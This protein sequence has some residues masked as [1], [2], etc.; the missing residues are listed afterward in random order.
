MVGDGRAPRP[1]SHAPSS[2]PQSFQAFLTAFTDTVHARGLAAVAPPPG[3]P[4]PRPAPPVL[5]PAA[6]LVAVGDLHG[7]LPKT[8]R[9]LKLAGVLG[10]DGRWCGGKAT[11][12][13]VGDI[14]D[15][16]GD[17]VAI[18]YLL[19]RLSKE[20]AAA[21]GAVHVLLGNH[22][23]LNVAG[24]YRYASPSG[25]DECD[26]VAAVDAIAAAFAAK[27]GCREPPA[28]PAVAAAVAA[29]PPAD[30]ARAALLAPGAPLT[31]RFLAPN[32][33]ALQVGSTVFVHGGLLP[34]HA[35]RGAPSLARINADTAAWMR[36]EAPAMPDILKGRDAVVWARDY[37]HE[38]AAACDCDAL[39][40]ALR[41]LPGAARMVVGHTIQEG[42]INAACGGAVLRV[43]VGLSAGCGDGGVQVLVVDRDCAVTRLVEGGAS[44]VRVPGDTASAK[45]GWWGAGGA[46]AAGGGGHPPRPVSAAA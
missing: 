2:R 11:L 39:R 16:G 4:I 20:A 21:G 45:R 46:G 26:R 6:R 36:G 17:E 8:R 32:R 13:Q 15:R 14:L 24:R 42:G 38:D 23:T 22:E 18:L 41:A 34:A 30:R 27:C 35:A 3:T 5:P 28:A 40:A 19:E 43:D 33:V 12:V 10:D 37:S 31:A 29:A 1:F 44:P 9:A 7:D 25:R